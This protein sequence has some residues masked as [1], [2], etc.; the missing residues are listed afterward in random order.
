MVDGKFFKSL[1]DHQRR[2]Q[3]AVVEV[4]VAVS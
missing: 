4:K 3:A 2:L 1:A